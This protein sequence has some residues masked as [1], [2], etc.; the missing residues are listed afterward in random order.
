MQA[1]R[2]AGRGNNTV[3]WHPAPPGVR[4][5]VAPCASTKEVAEC[6]RARRAVCLNKKGRRALVPLPPPHTTTTNSRVDSVRPL[7][8]PQCF[9]TPM[10]STGVAHQTLRAAHVPTPTL[11]NSSSAVGGATCGA[12]HPCLGRRAHYFG[13]LVQ[14][15]RRFLKGGDERKK[16][17]GACGCSALGVWLQ[18]VGPRSAKPGNLFSIHD[19]T[20]EKLFT[21]GH[22]CT[23]TSPRQAVHT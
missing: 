12:M 19:C 3:H 23:H 9:A 21:W 17:V 2:H 14:V 4:G 7:I 20:H 10:E 1:P 6:A 8:C 11:R 5:H 18:R 22:C 13:A 15:C 16:N